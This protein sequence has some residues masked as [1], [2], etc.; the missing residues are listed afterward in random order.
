ME[1]LKTKYNEYI[2]TVN[3]SKSWK[4]LRFLLHW[5][6]IPVKLIRNGFVG[7]SQMIANR[8]AKIRKPL[9]NGVPPLQTRQHYFR[10]IFNALPLLKTTEMNTYVT[11]VPY[12]SIPNGY[13]HNPKMQ[14]VTHS[15]YYFLM[16]KLGLQNEKMEVATRMLMQG[17]WLCNG[18]IKNPYNPTVDYNVRSVGAN[19]LIGLNLAIMSQGSPSEEFDVLITSILEH[20]Y[21]LLEYELVDG[22]PGYELYKKLLKSNSYR[23]EKVLM[24]SHAGMF[25]PGL[26]LNGTNAL[27]ILA[28][29]RVAQVKNGNREAGKVYRKLLWQYGYGLLSMIPTTSTDS[30]AL[31]ALY[32]LSKLSKS[33]LGKL[34]WKI[35]MLFTWALSKH[36]FNSYYTGL[37]KE[38][39]PGTI[40]KEYVDQCLTYLYEM[41]PKEYSYINGE[42]VEVI[43]V[44]ASQFLLNASDFS[45]DV[46]QDICIVENENSVKI[47][48]GLGF[49][50]CAIMLE[51]SPKGLING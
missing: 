44:P 39:Y 16:S 15:T 40:S 12:Y 24:K 9:A 50:A 8:K 14:C 49:I 6:S 29:L 4:A 47:K 45:P 11:Q 32:T 7:T 38:C 26:E 21:S 41:E 28:A 43:E 17:K 27:A 5:I 1:K 42:P 18:F 48:T 20:D 3:P 22:D 10:K 31:V 46:R 35:P 13:N 34:F 37:V 36:W 23:P 30:S 19:Q 25:Q 33:K 2:L 51:D